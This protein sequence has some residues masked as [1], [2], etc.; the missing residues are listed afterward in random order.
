MKK[1]YSLSLAISLLSA[2]CWAMPQEMDGTNVETNKEAEKQKLKESIQNLESQLSEMEKFGEF[3]GSFFDLL[4]A[5]HGP[6]ISEYDIRNPTESIFANLTDRFEAVKKY[7]TSNEFAKK[8]ENF[9]NN[10]KNYL[11]VLKVSEDIAFQDPANKNRFTKELKEELFPE[12]VAK[13]IFSDVENLLTLVTQAI[14]AY[15]T[16]K[17]YPDWAKEAI[18][19]FVIEKGYMNIPHYANN[20]DKANMP[21]VIK[22]LQELYAR[23]HNGTT[24]YKIQSLVSNAEMKKEILE[25]FIENSI[26]RRKKELNHLK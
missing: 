19:N 4:P 18:Q 6:I 2:S 23:L 15:P 7:L 22:A 8:L 14:E 10:F 1:I 24:F 5:K 17:S 13:T 21:I 25:T 26:S 3:E 12:A 20:H 9:I 16:K 11:D